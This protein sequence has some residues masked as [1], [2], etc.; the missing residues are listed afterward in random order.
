[1]EDAKLQALHDS[2]AQL[3]GHQGLG[4]S[5][6]YSWQRNSQTTVDY[7]LPKNAL[8]A[9]FVPQ[10]T[11][12]PTTANDGDG[13]IVK[14]DF[15]DSSKAERKAAKKAAAKAAK[16]EAKRQAKLEEKKRQKKEAK[17]QDE[18]KKRKREEQQSAGDS[19]EE[20]KK[21]KKDKKK[22]DKKR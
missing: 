12:D 18:K 20:K 3:K 7:G 4:R 10:G 14:R 6:T 15:S 1:M 8:Y 19:S 17:Q 9:N 16:L 13:R 21:A 22:K 2:L 11:Y 5:S